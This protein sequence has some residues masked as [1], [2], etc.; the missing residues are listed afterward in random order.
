MVKYWYLT[1]R[2]KNT[3]IRGVEGRV[4]LDGHEETVI[5]TNPVLSGSFGTRCN[6]TTCLQVGCV[7]VIVITIIVN[8]GDDAQSFTHVQRTLHE[9]RQHTNITVL[10]ILICGNSNIRI[11]R[12]FMHSTIVTK[13]WLVFGNSAESRLVVCRYL[14]RVGSSQYNVWSLVYIV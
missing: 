11:P 6:T 7:M 4:L 3:H 5:G 1:A 10:K 14:P 8:S 12:I 13:S 9:P 2:R